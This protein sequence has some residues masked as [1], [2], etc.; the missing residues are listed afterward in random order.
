MR[1]ASHLCIYIRGCWRYETVYVRTVC[2]CKER[3]Y[4]YCTYPVENNMHNLILC[5]LPCHISSRTH[6]GILYY[7]CIIM[8]MREELLIKYGQ[9]VMVN[10]TVPLSG[11]LPIFF[12][13]YRFEQSYWLAVILDC[14]P[15]TYYQIIC[16]YCRWHL[17]G[18]VCYWF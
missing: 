17:Y 10:V 8:E 5:Y 1:N 11:T 6:F 14:R 15:L 12:I 4:A 16:V 7:K 13:E 9:N 18:C 3:Y 2:S